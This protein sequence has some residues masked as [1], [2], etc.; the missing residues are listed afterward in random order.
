MSF[1]WSS[2]CLAFVALTLLSSSI[3]RAALPTEEEARALAKEH[4]IKGT[5]LFELGR[6]D[7]AIREYEEA[8]KYKDDPVLLYNLGQAHRLAGHTAEA[9]RFY[10]V[11]IQKVPNARNRAEVQMKIA[12]LERLLDEQRK[13]QNIP[14]DIPIGPGNRQSLDDSRTAMTEPERRGTTSPA[15]SSATSS[16][17]TE[18]ERRATTT[19]RE[20]ERRIT[21]TTSATTSSTIAVKKARVEHTPGFAKRVAGFTCIGVGVAAVAA[22][23]GMG[24]VAA[25][26]SNDVTETARSRGVF[27][28][29]KES[30]GETADIVQ[31]VLY[32]V[33]VATIATGVTLT[34]L[35]Y[36]DKRSASSRA[37]LL[38]VA[39]QRSAGVVFS[40]SF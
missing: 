9:I 5:K 32:G 11:F 19:A 13:T 37:M 14:P 30:T 36:R 39:G 24:V 27:D 10:K 31:G 2:H 35:G 28:P 7:D 4:F 8:Y 3:A 15:T 12:A 20:P 1:R 18:P 22:G 33:G 25:G 21:T 23:I 17:T 16:T 29:A 38:P 26:A 40:A 34:V 6:F